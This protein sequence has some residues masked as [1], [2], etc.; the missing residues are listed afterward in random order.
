MPDGTA[1]AAATTADRRALHKKW[2]AKRSNE[3]MT[4]KS[5][6]IRHVGGEQG[7]EHRPVIADLWLDRDRS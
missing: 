1:L 2:E 4:A 5:E 6:L 3:W 7:S